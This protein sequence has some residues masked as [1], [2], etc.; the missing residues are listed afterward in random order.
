MPFL[1]S[2]D[3]EIAQTLDT[4]DDVRKMFTA[5]NSDEPYFEELLSV[6]PQAVVVGAQSAGKSS[7]LRRISGISLP[8][9]STL[10]TR[11]ATVI[12]I[13]RSLM[14]SVS[15][16]LTGPSGNTLQERR[17]DTIAEVQKVVAEA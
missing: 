2:A 3:S 6:L 1:L 13:R 14:N 11:M 12:R 15:V 16:T 17:C 4:I 9:A 7:A 10:C 5:Q 8:E